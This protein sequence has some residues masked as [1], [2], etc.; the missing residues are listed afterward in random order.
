MET[1]KIM[2]VVSL[3]V[4]FTACEEEMRREKINI[5]YPT[6]AKVDTVTNY[7]GTDVKDPYR[8]LEDDMSEETKAW[9]KEENKTTFGYLDNIPFR[10]ELKERLTS[11]WNYEKVGAPFKEGDYTY[12][13]KNEWINVIGSLWD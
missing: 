10:E 4:G 12:Y 8:W 3:F 11:L 5:S 1:L 13:Y 2:L 6:T 9:V 7:F